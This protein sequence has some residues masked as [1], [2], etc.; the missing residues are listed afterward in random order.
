MRSTLT[1]LLLGTLA[2]AGCRG[3]APRGDPAR[4]AESTSRAWTDT[5]ETA[6]H[7]GS[8]VVRWRTTP[9]EILEGRPFAVEAWVFGA[10]ATDVPLADV[11]LDVDAGMPQHGHG[12]AALARV[13]RKG[14]GWRADGLRFHMAGAW[15]L[16]FDVTRGARTER[17]QAWITLE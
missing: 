6:T 2:A 7:A 14:D 9:P 15:E 13:E 16:V 5:T 4:G 11:E 17:A 8:Y 3:D 12:M 10:G 1:T